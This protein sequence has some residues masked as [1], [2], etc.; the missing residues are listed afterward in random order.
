MSTPTRPAPATRS[1]RTAGKI[2]PEHARAHNRALVLQSLFSQGAM[3]RADLARE[4]GLTRVTISD[5]VGGLIDDGY[6][7]EQGV[8]EASGPGKPAILVDIDRGGHRIAGLDLSGSESFVGAVLTLD[9]EIV[10]RHS[11]AVPTDRRYVFDAIAELARA[12]IADAHAP[13][14]GLGVGTPGVVDDRGVVLAAPGFGWTEVDLAGRLEAEL[15]LPVLVANDAN[16]AVLAEHTFGGAGDDVI[17]IR[18][19]RG[20]GAGLLTGG[21]PLAGARF[22]AGE[23]GHVTVGTDGGPACACGKIGCLEA[24]LAV[25]ALTERLAAAD[26]PQGVLRDAGERLGIALA[27][28]V[29]ALDLSEITLSGPAD[30]LGG[31]L[32]EAAAETVRTRTLAT[33]HDGLQVRMSAHSEDIVL[34]GAAVMVLSGRLGVS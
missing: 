26:D 4:T 14:L 16:A 25:P 7:V 34:R 19:G 31:T 2:L 1:R 29:G 22:A 11:V 5:L 10:A 12:V 23:I 8:R 20:V 15:D 6:V 9:G 32:A 13:V 33:F 30:L 18:V 24:W 17:L 28:I 27:P 21:E 3:S